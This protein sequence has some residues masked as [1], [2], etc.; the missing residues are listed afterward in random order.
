MNSRATW[1]TVLGLSL[2]LGHTLVQ[3]QYTTEEYAIYETAVNAAPAERHDAI[4]GF[5]D[6]NP[7]SA[8]VE[9][10][11]GSYLQLMQ[12]Y[13]NQGQSG[14][15]VSSGEKLLGI[16]PDNLNAQYMVAIAAY[17]IKDFGKATNYGESIYAARPDAGLAFVLANSFGQLKN[18]D[19][20]IEYGAKAC[21]ELAPKDC[22]QLLGQISKIYAGKKEW[23]KAAEYAKRSVEGLDAAGKPG[24]M[25]DSEWKNYITVEKATAYTGLGRSAAER[26][27]WDTAI[28][29][30]Q[31]VISLSTDPSAKAEAYYYTGMG[32]WD[33]RQMDS[34]MDAFA[35]GAVQKDAP[36]AQHCRQYLETLYKSTHNGSLAGLEEFII[37]V[38]R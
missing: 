25:S 33:Q 34:A 14:Q 6:A 24:Q 12:E 30:Y 27:N 8:L 1:K 3:G 5:I 32:R 29:N 23:A 35:K 13:Q 36:H 7:Q 22:F 17:Q 9:Y 38:T 37:R 11:V 28:A 16:I 26:E 21:S 15:V 10:A 18:Q 31:K 19:K 4:I 2:V 20:Q